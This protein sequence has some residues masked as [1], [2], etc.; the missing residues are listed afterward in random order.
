MNRLLKI[1]VWFKCKMAKLLGDVGPLEDE[2]D[3]LLP[4]VDRRGIL[5]LSDL[6]AMGIPYIRD[7][8][9]FYD[10]QYGPFVAHN[11]GGGDCNT[12]NYITALSLSLVMPAKEIWLVTY[13]A[14]P[15]KCSHTT[16]VILDGDRY[17]NYD[18]GKR[19]IAGHKTI[20]QC[21]SELARCKYNAEVKTWI[22]QNIS[23]EII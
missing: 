13:I 14:K 22:K 16:V 15:F 17:F 20:D 2:R 8:W 5:E 9:P 19:G 1:W 21:I 18:Y 6:I 12:L 23:L 7:G 3:W 11:R 10:W 4:H